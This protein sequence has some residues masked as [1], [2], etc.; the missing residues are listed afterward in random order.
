MKQNS[1][2]ETDF[3]EQFSDT[4]SSD[5]EDNIFEQ[6]V[7]DALFEAGYD[8][9]DINKITGSGPGYTTPQGQNISDSLKNFK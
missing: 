9:E 6:D 2:K 4:E 5:D 3:E 8:I 7:Y 1:D